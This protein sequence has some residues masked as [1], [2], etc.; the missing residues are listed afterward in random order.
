MDN[1]PTTAPNKNWENFFAKFQEISTLPTSEW[2]PPHIVGY[3]CKKFKDQYNKDYVFKFNNSAPGKS[4]EVFIIKKICVLMSSD[5]SILKEYIDWVFLEKISKPR[6]KIRSIS[7]FSNEEILQEYKMS[8]LLNKSSCEKIDRTTNL[9]DKYKI[10]FN[11]ILN[12]YGDLSFIYKMEKIPE[13]YIDGFS[14]LEELGFNFSI[15]DRV[16]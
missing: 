11:N 9:P 12:T 1:L 15:L 10:L 16:V 5:P 4:F 3:F 14:K 7:F 2:K 8:F 13:E 6:K